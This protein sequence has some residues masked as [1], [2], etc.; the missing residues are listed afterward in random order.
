MSARIQQYS[1]LGTFDEIIYVTSLLSLNQ[2]SR[3]EDV[4]KICIDKAIGYYY[5]FPGILALL[6]FI[7]AIKIIDDSLI[8]K[9]GTFA[10]SS[11][12]DFLNKLLETLES[13]KLIDVLFAAPGAK[14]DYVNKRICLT[15]NLLD[16]SAQ[17]IKD[18]LVDLGYIT[19]LDPSGYT[20]MVG[21]E[22]FLAAIKAIKEI[23][24]RKIA[25]LKAIS[26]EE[27]EALQLYKSKIGFEAEQAVLKY[28]LNRLSSHPKKEEIIIIS[29]IDITA[30]YDLNSFNTTD[31]K[32]IDR[33]I[34]VKSYRGKMGFYISRN[35]LS[36]A[37]DKGESYYLYLVDRNTIGTIDFAPTIIQ[38]PYKNI[39]NSKV[40]KGSPEA[41]HFV[42]LE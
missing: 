8:E 4:R 24:K 6:E 26:M 29:E 9:T 35:E 7:G 39:L 33:F 17:G 16:K 1:A 36:K 28:E 12:K 31:S 27:F 23:T 15:P 10:I 18:L 20:L 5:S 19:N 21:Q 40:W 2:R 42:S 22:Y 38:D 41:W 37:E 32:L 34:E 13:N 3:I 25:A 11:K 30:G 14:Y